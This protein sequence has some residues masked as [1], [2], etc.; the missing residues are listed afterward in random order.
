MCISTA[1]VN[2]LRGDQLRCEYLMWF[3]MG[4]RNSVLLEASSTGN[5]RKVLQAV[6]KPGVAD[7][8]RKGQV[9][10]I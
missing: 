3:G 10:L 1:V 2:R 9:K 5:L 4:N 6:E 7:V 8:N